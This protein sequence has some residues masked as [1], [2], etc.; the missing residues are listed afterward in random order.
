MISKGVQCAETGGTA[1]QIGRTHV[2]GISANGVEKSRLELIHLRTN[3]VSTE[4]AE[5]RVRPCVRG[6]LVARVIGIADNLRLV[7]ISDWS[8]PVGTARGYYC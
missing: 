3:A 6:N 7:G 4:G 8:T 5:I 2:C 1:A